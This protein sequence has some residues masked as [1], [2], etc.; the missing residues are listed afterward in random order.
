M[1]NPHYPRHILRPDGA[2]IIVQ[3]HHQ[4]SAHMGRKFGPD[5]QPIEER[6]MPPT[7]EEILAAETGYS[8]EA[9][10]Q[11]F[12]TQRAMFEQGIEPYGDKPESDFLPPV[13]DPNEYAQNPET[14]GEGEPDPPILAPELKP[15]DV[16]TIASVNA[17]NPETGD[18]PEPEPE[19]V[20]DGADDQ[21]VSDD[22]AAAEGES[23]GEPV[24]EESVEP[25][26]GEAAEAPKPKNRG[27]RPR[28]VQG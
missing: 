9:A 10:Q 15:G 27:G 5:A 18:E 6:P 28:K 26:I 16:I 13:T 23:T 12:A 19:P 22:D 11:I 7:L 1:S 21:P 3:D 8:Q 4:H 14:M 24:G 17:V 2:T 20:L 25:P